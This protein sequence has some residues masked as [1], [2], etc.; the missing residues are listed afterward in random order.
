MI[1][2]KYRK[3]F[4]YFPSADCLKFF[5]EKYLKEPHQ[6]RFKLRFLDGLSVSKIASAEGVSKSTV[7]RS[8]TS[9]VELFLAVGLMQIQMTD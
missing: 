9:S 7:S 3:Y 1:F 6:K 4:G 2:S 8:L 5:A